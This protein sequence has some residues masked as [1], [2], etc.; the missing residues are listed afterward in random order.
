METPSCVLDTISFAC[1]LQKSLELTRVD[2]KVERLKVKKLKRRKPF[3]HPLAPI[4]IGREK[5]KGVRGK[6][7]F[8]Y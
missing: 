3:R 6:K 1:R 4:G 8:I 2:D 5:R 7:I